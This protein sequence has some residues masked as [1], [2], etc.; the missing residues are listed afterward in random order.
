MAILAIL[1][2]IAPKAA[3]VVTLPTA[4][5][6]LV[7][8][9]DLKV[10]PSKA[11]PSPDYVP[12]SP[13]HAP[14]SPDYHPGSDTKSPPPASAIPLS[15]VPS[16]HRRSSLSPPNT[17][18]KA[19]MPEFVIPEATST[20]SPVRRHRIIEGHRWA[21]SRDVA[22]IE[23]D[24]YKIETMCSRA[25]WAEAQVVVLQSLLGIAGVRIAD[26]EF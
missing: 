14:V 19:I 15:D 2:E 16:P 8:E 4:A 24:E 21:F 1:P 3:A 9:S 22:R 10:E 20:V 17:T 25:M 23:S 6:D 26:L 18:T 12:S 5:L 7:I 13:I 11:L